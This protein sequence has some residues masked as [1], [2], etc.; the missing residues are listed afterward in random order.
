[1]EDFNVNENF[2]IDEL[3][4][5]ILNNP[6]IS[7]FIVRIPE[8]P[9]HIELHNNKERFEEVSSDLNKLENVTFIDYGLHEME[10][11]FFRD[12]NHLSKDGMNYFTEILYNENRQF[13]NNP[14]K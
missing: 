2:E 11:S 7:F 14:I 13:F 12:F 4:K 1:M 3:M 9:I 10:N 6:N 5:T 8:H